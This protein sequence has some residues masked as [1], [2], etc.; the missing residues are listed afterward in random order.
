MEL[1]SERGFDRTTIEEIAEACDVSPRTFFR[2]FPTKEDVLFGD[3]ELRCRA[4]LDVLTAQP[5]DRSPLDALHAAMRAV[6]LAYRD[7]R[8]LLALRHRVVL[9]SPG[10]R[11]YKAEHQR[12]WEQSVVDELTRRSAIA[13]TDESA[14]ELRL[15]SSAAIGALRAALDTWLEDTT[16]AAD[17]VTLL[18]TAFELT[19]H[20]FGAGRS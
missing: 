18:D 3:S 10:L 8:E 2:Y 6:A 5:A 13:G 17:I 9:G 16:G 1:F 19:A 20:G 4:L 12:G 11:A 7:E 15:L 14:L